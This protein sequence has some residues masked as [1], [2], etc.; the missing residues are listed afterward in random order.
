MSNTGQ[1]EGA[2]RVI[3]G[4]YDGRLVVLSIVIAIL[5]AYAA[6]DLSGRL[7]VS[8]GR[9]RIAWLC[10]GAFSMGI[11]IWSMHYV[12]ME[13]LRLPVQVRYDWPTV[14][15]SMAVAILAS[16]VALFVASRN[17]LTTTVA[18]LGSVS[19]GG[20]DKTDGGHADIMHYRNGQTHEQGIARLL[21]TPGG[22]VIPDSEG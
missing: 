19:K 3:H 17:T 13:A 2:M 22:G 14:L 21:P 10:G 8:H 12:G 4:F 7:T 11:G 9:A 20:G 1:V 18:V 16:A 15:L 5:A 6:L